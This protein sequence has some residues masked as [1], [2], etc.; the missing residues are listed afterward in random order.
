MLLE[1][2]EMQNIDN[3]GKF[4]FIKSKLLMM[5]LVLNTLIGLLL[6]VAGIAVADARWDYEQIKS[7]PKAIEST[8]E[9]LRAMADD[10]WH[11]Y[12]SLKSA[13][14]AT[15]VLLKR[16]VSIVEVVLVSLF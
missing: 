10:G 4:G 12:G 6:V 13:D 16:K 15:W 11:Q 1:K 14:G 5:Q 2:L 3:Q 8:Q 9:T 7:Y